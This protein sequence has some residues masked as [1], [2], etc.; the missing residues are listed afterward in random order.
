M[1]SWK[2]QRSGLLWVAIV[3]LALA[4][5]GAAVL[6]AQIAA[7]LTGSP[8][9]WPIGSALFARL[10]LCL[11][12]LLLAGAL[13][14][15]VA[16]TLTL[17]Y[18]MDRNGLYISWLGNRAVVPLQQIESIESGVHAPLR[19]LDR[20]RSL[21]YYHG[22][23]R[24]PEGRVVHRFST[25][26]LDRAL[27]VHTTAD[28]YAISP[29]DPNAFVQ[30][31]EQRRRIGAVQ[32]LAP[33][34]E[35]GRAFT[36]AFWDDQVV[37]RALALAL[38][39]NLALLGW[40]MTIYPGLPPLVD[41]RADATGAAAALVPRHQILFL[42]LAGAALALLNLGLGL[43]FYRREPAGA[44]LLQIASVGVQALFVVAALTILR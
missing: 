13:A 7:A 37:R 22:R 21:G 9:A 14:Y 28:S 42:P 27:V 35:A 26:G 15:R 16:A 2:P 36:Y 34:V 24:L 33:G 3:A 20:V 4:L 17:A 25:I 32:Q 38:L 29:Q 10:L 12:L 30:D 19:P 44:R 1:R 5:A 6:L 43:G 41:L 40:L 23:V 31:L 39:L 11:A 18:S 8:A